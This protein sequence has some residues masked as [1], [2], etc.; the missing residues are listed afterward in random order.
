MKDLIKS[1]FIIYLAS[2]LIPIIAIGQAENFDNEN[3]VA[4]RY[5]YPE[6]VQRFIIL[7]P[8][9]ETKN[10]LPVL[11]IFPDEAENKKIVQS[12]FVNSY[13]REAV[14]FYFLVQ[15][16]LKNQKNLDSHEPAYLLLSNTQGGYPRFGFYLKIGDEYQNKEKIPYID[17]V[18]NNTREENYLGSMTQIYPHEMGHIL[19]QM[20][21]R[22]TNETVPVH[23]SSDIHYVNLTTDYR[24]AFNE[25]FAISFE[26]LAREYE[27]DEKLKQ[28]IFRDFEFKKNRIKQS[29]S[30]YDHDFRLPLRL[31][32]YRTTMILWYQ[33][34]ENIKRYE[35]V[36]LGLIKYRN[37]TINS[38]NVEKAL[39]Y[40]NSGVGF[41]KPYLKPLQRALATEGVVSS[42]F[43]K[44][45]E[46]NLKNKY[47][48]PE[49]YAQFMLDTENLPFKPEQVFVPIENEMLKIFVVLHKHLDTKKTQKSQLLD[50]VE[51][52]A[53][54][55]PQEKDEIY[56]IFEFASGYKIPAR[57]GPEIWMLNKEHKHGFFVMDQFGGNVL[58]F[59]TFNLNA[60]DIFD[61]LT[62][63]EVPKDEAQ[64]VLDYRDQKGFITDLDEIFRIPE[65]SKQTAEFLKNSAY[66]ASYLE[67]FEEEDFFN[68][69]KMILMTIGHLL[70]R[71]LFYFLVFI[72]IYFLFLKNLIGQKKFSVKIVFQK[73]LKV[74]L[75]VFFGLAS[76]IFSGNPITLFLIFSLILIFIE[77]I[78]RSDTFK[79]KD[80]LISSVIIIVMVLYS[81]W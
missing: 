3:L 64:H 59:Y 80:A 11:E 78:I 50:F 17:L 4:E 56:N 48:S 36:K 43:Y 10:D 21:A 30:G 70:L 39:Y 53:A 69:P 9:D 49:F 24:T 55:F 63:H 2:I 72:I 46:S 52:Y 61:L 45:F 33:K 81:L 54:E 5:I 22:T 26:N 51:G 67:S 77:F 7:K 57:M 14:K 62:F 74:A 8:T 34:F 35:W 42:F 58:P 76:V 73:L 75:F 23:E 40:R 79:R 47:L 65:V 15:N 25:G 29:V 13:M 41:V 32:Y 44:L 16:Y 6:K 27:P 37:T 20:L 60:V 68:I 71:S 18:K 31:D 66:D 28:D 12:L 19:Y 1:I 38:R